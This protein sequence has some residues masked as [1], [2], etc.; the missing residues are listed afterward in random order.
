MPLHIPIVPKLSRRSPS[1]GPI[2]ASARLTSRGKRRSAHSTPSASP[3]RPSSPSSPVEQSFHLSTAG[4][5]T[6]WLT[7]RVKSNASPSKTHP[8]YFD[9]DSVEGSVCLNLT[10]QTMSIVS[11]IVIVSRPAILSPYPPFFNAYQ[12]PRSVVTY[13]QQELITP[14]FL[15][16]P[17]PCGR[18]TWDIRQRSQQTHCTPTVSHFPH[19]LDD[20]L[21]VLYGHF[22]YHYHRMCSWPTTR[23]IQSWSPYHRALHPREYRPLSITGSKCSYGEVL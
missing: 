22:R 23:A 3:S 17:R 12:R 4:C 15:N 21:E 13:S 20:S 14:P 5:S 6:P 9:R 2:T 16:C 18:P 19:S 1:T 10:E 8:L 11:I 7:M